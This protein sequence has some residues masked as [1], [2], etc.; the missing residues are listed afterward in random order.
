MFV[1][2]CL[3]R[4]ESRRCQ[5]ARVL[6]PRSQ[7]Q[8]AYP[9]PVVKHDK[10]GRMIVSARMHSGNFRSIFSNAD[11]ICTLTVTLYGEST[12][13]LQREQPLLI[14]CGPLAEWQRCSHDTPDF[15]ASGRFTLSSDKEYQPTSTT[16]RSKDG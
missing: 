4:L 5:V 7:C 11:G 9:S 2:L 14:P 8:A 10:V 13:K 15:F 6:S 16:G 12:P 1:C 3:S